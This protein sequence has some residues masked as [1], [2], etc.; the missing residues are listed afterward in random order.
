MQNHQYGK[1]SVTVFFIIVTVLSAICEAVYCLGGNENLIALLMWMPALAAIIAAHI[2]L[3]ET[4]TKWSFKNI[5][6]L[7]SLRRAKLRYILLGALIPFVYLLIPYMIYWHMY[8]ENFAYTGVPFSVIFKDLAVYTVVYVFVGL[9]TALGEE[10]GWRGFMVPALNERIGLKKTLLVSSLF[11]CLWHFPILIWGDYMG[12]TALWYQLLSFVLC[13]LPVG[14]IA[15]LLRI[16]SGSVW[17][18]A[19]LHA[20][21]NA[22]DQAV[23]GVI[24]R[25]DNRMYYVSE[26]GMFTIICVWILGLIVWYVYKKTETKGEGK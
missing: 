26:T 24:T 13:I 23:F 4:G 9:I 3:K 6:S 14:V 20:A 2:S 17:P 1:R 10:L 5:C 22:Y 12:G 16:R 25:G 7:I 19:F 18:A 11:W 21:H 15:G 8:P